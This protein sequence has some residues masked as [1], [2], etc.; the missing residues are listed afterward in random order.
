VLCGDI[1]RNGLH[2]PGTFRSGFHELG[3]TSR[4]DAGTTANTTQE[5]L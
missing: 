2:E 4:Y 1:F 5:R 3:F